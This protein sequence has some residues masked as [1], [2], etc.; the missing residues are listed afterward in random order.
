MM[1]IM[2]NYINEAMIKFKSFFEPMVFRKDVTDYDKILLKYTSLLNEMGLSLTRGRFSADSTHNSSGFIRW[3]KIGIK[4]NN[5]STELNTI[6][7]KS[8]N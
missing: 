2:V 6:D 4:E 3:N 8:I 1:K 5:D 7:C